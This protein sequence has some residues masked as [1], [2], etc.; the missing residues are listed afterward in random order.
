MSPDLERP[1]QLVG[2]EIEQVSRIR[3]PSDAR[4]TPLD[5]IGQIIAA[6]EV[7]DLQP[8]DLR[9]A[10]V[11][12]PGQQRAARTWLT[13][14]DVHVSGHCADDVLVQEEGSADSPDCT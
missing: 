14:A 13:R 2:H 12:R 5:V 6:T 8:V 3:R 7:P 1:V 4:V 10:G 11:S 9:A